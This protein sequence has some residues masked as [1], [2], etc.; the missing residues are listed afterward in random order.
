[1]TSQRQGDAGKI[2]CSPAPPGFFNF[3]TWEEINESGAIFSEASPTDILVAEPV[4][5]YREFRMRCLT[6]SLNVAEAAGLPERVLVSVRL[7][8]L[9]SIH[10]KLTRESKYNLGLLNDIIGIRI[11]CQTLDD[12][13]A[14]SDRI[15]SSCGFSCKVKDYI[16]GAENRAKT[17]YRAI[18]HILHFDQPVTE[19][20]SLR[21]GFEIQVKSFYQHQ[22]A[23]LQEKHGENVKAGYKGG[24]PGEEHLEAIQ[25][26]REIS[27]RIARRENNHPNEIQKDLPSFTSGRNIAVVWRPPTS[28]PES[29]VEP[30]FELFQN[31]EA[32]TTQLNYLEGHYP[33]EP[34]HALLLVGVSRE[35][36]AKKILSMTHP[37]YVVGEA[38]PPEDWMLS[39]I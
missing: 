31:V 38:E 4:Q 20:A 6:T 2:L 24:E 25:R 39:N 23:I 27:A 1:M 15:Q 16:R 18:H 32:A 5:K 17:G 13:I 14:L 37:L 28:E 11:V 30:E 29:A 33:S 35:S 26:W 9:V 8:R 22:W 12:V 7:K 34:I 36:D 3:R 10:R 19:D 21:V